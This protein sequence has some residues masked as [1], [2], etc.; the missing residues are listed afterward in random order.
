MDASRIVALACLLLVSSAVDAGKL[1]RARD[2]VRTPAPVSQP[3]G[4]GKLERASQSTRSEEPRHDEPRRRGRRGCDLG[5][6]GWG[7]SIGWTLPPARPFYVATPVCMEQ[8]PV[9]YTTPKPI[10]YP[11][12]PAVD[13]SFA[14]QFAAHPFA[15]GANGFFTTMGDGKPW[16]GKL[17]IEIGDGSDEVSRTGYAFLIESEMGLGL[18]IDWDSFTEDLPGGGHDE[19]HLGQVN[20]TYRVFESERALIRAGVGVGWLGDS[21]GTESGVNLTL[22]ADLLPSE[23]WIASVDLDFGT[24]G[25]AE[26]QHVSATIGRRLGPCEI[27]GGYDYRRL[28][29]VSL[30]GP[31]IGLRLWW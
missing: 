30:Y 16:L 23:D 24:L 10:P 12:A 14:E 21:I 25:D 31:M 4:G 8:P 5:C 6:S 15:N 11:V 7:G 19:L 3:S 13:R 27:Y 1:S 9:V 29:E 18:D 26:T 2:Q 17:Q 28:G 22:Q 20:V